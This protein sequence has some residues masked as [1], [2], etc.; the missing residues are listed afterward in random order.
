M[1]PGIYCIEN[2][3]S[4]KKYIGQA[5]DIDKRKAVHFSTLKNGVH[6][7]RHLQN[8][9]NKDGEDAFSFKILAYC[10][11]S[12]LTYYEQSFVDL[13]T[14][15]KLY[16]ICLE[17]VN[18]SIGIKHSD[19][20]KLLMSKNHADYSGENH[21]NFGKRHSKET[22]QKM[23][24]AKLGEKHPNFGKH[25]SKETKIKMSEAQKGHTLSE[26][27]RKKISDAHKGLS[28]SADHANAIS[29]GLMGRTHSEE[30][31]MK[32]SDSKRKWWRAKREGRP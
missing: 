31:K 5:V 7:N 4:G 8:S 28:L 23:S 29:K 10:E 2:T 20:S 26:K 15:E 24:E 9:F 6:Y 17:C 16:N 1:T 25:A 21:P 3:L 12:E 11:T 18:S 13:Y 19:E 27:S 14:P 32:M 22:I 30:T